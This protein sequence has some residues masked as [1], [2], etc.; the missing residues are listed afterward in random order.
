MLDAEKSFD[1][2]RQ[3]SNTHKQDF[4]PVRNLRDKLKKA[5][6]NLEKQEL[7]KKEEDWFHKKFEL[8][9]A[10]RK[11]KYWEFLGTKQKINFPFFTQFVRNRTQAIQDN[12]YLK[13]HYV[14]TSENPCVQG[15]RGAEPKKLGR[16][17]F[18]GPNWLS[19]PDKWPSH[20]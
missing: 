11:Q 18:E 16:L 17:W 4:I 20:P 5:L 13:W 10:L 14:P 1:E 12:G 6:N 9:L 2:V 7:H 15:S 3:W 8:E 19:S